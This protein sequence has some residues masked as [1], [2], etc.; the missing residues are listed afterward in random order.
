MSTR[1]LE[2]ATEVN[3][4]EVGDKIM[5]LFFTSNSRIL[6]HRFHSP[7]LHKE[8]VNNLIFD[9]PF[10]QNTTSIF[11]CFPSIVGVKDVL[12]VY[13]SNDQSALRSYLLLD[14]TIDYETDIYLFS[15]DLKWCIRYIDEFY[16]NNSRMTFLYSND[17]LI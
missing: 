16:P 8:T 10:F 17:Q 7:F 9:A 12:E 14:D 6:E 1:N 11:V 3:Q 15:S 4:N 13:I 5:S 2:F